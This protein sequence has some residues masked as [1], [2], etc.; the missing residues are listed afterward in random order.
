MKDAQGVNNWDGSERRE[1]MKEVV[2]SLND[3]KLVLAERK[4]VL[5]LILKHEKTLYGN[6]QEGLT[7]KIDHIGSMRDE[8]RLHGQYDHRFFL[9]IITVLLAILGKLFIVK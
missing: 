7:T 9:V 5:D 1:G 4:P 6:G 8:I 2:N 3:I